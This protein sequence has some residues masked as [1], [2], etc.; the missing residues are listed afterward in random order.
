MNDATPP[1]YAVGDLVDV[2][3]EKIVPGGH[4]L[5][6]VEG[7]T[8]FVDLAVVGD[9]L[10]VSLREI[11]G[12]IAFADTHSIIEPSP[13]R[14]EPPCLYVGICGGCNFQQMTYRA[15]LDAKLGIIRDCLHRI[16]KLDYEQEIPIIA[17][18]AEF[19][20]RLRAQWH[21]D[22]RGHRVG[23]YRQ[24]SRELVAI[25]HCPILLRSLDA[26]LQRV[27]GEINWVEFWPD[28]GAVDAAVGDVDAVSVDSEELGLR[29]ESVTFTAGGEKYAFAANVFFQ[30]NKFLIDK[31][32][33]TAIGEA[34]GET[35]LDLYAG[36]GLFTVPLARR[37]NK[38][39]AVEEYGAAVRFARKNT[40]ECLNVEIIEKPVGRFLAEH[41]GEIDFALLDPPRSGTEKK[42]VLD[43]IRLKP[44]RVAYVSCDPSVL[45]R[46]VRRF[47]DGGYAIESITA[48]DLFPQ[49]HHVETVVHFAIAGTNPVF[50]Q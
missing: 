30:G 43:L 44:K 31:L 49:T 50:Q 48:I 28:N 6:F 9:R 32:I 10:R 37:F 20:Y 29:A 3:I 34:A 33:E 7:L 46:D 35:A 8:I 22:G 40:A 36:V 47:L 17:S 14:I 1:K 5:A 13:D 2:R 12:K 41:R 27:R 4:G 25:E 19:G 15:Q 39:T 21:I 18:P 26:V 24:N 16:G 45:A 23:Y 38:V 11:K 42:T